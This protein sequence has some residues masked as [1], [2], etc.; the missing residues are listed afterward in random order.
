MQ[1]R[2]VRHPPGVLCQNWS[3]T[4]VV[5]QKSNYYYMYV[6]ADTNQWPVLMHMLG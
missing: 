6:T 5:G 4:Y 3:Y 2:V 1:P